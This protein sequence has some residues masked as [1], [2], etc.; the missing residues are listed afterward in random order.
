MGKDL[1]VGGFA[2]EGFSWVAEGLAEL[3][4]LQLGP[5]TLHG[6]N[7]SKFRFNLARF[8]HK[9][10]LLSQATTNTTVSREH[11]LTDRDDE[12]QDKSKD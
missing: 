7:N 6:E 4:R 5:L 3:L 9:R 2:V 10:R 1:V 8:R 11:F 12:E